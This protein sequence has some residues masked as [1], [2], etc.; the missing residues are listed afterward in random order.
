VFRQPGSFRTCFEVGSRPSLG[1]VRARFFAPFFNQKG[2]AVSIL[3][4]LFGKKEKGIDEL[5]GFLKIGARELEMVMISY[6]EFALKKRNGGIRTICSPDTELKKIQR[7]INRRLLNGM[8]AHYSSTGFEPGESIVYNADSHVGK[9]VVIKLD[10]R[11]FFKSTGE[12]RVFAY[13]RKIGWNQEA[14]ELLTKLTTWKGSLPQGAPTSPRLSNLV[15]FRLDSRLAGF[16]MQIGGDYTRYADDIT[17]SLDEDDK[18]KVTQVLSFV[19]MILLE[20]GYRPNKQKTRVMRRHQQQR[21]TGLVVNQKIQLPRQTRKWLRAVKHR[22]GLTGN[23][24]LNENQLK[25]WLALEKMV[26]VQRG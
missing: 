23:C 24:S 19:R 11:D 3:S 2:F 25:G 9:A 5:C 17:I 12:E 14:A 8:Q 26:E 22:H 20:F 13:F 6:R 16:A 18:F 4:W 7:L 15:N 21:I 1:R 10:I